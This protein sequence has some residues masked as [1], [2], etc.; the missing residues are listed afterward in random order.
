VTNHER[1]ICGLDEAGAWSA[2][3]TPSLMKSSAGLRRSLSRIA[4][5][6]GLVLIATIAP[7]ATSD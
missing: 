6:A 4:G 5:Q 3:P 7:A 2:F 1:S